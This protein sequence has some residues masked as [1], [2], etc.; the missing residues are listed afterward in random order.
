MGDVSAAL[1]NLKSGSASDDGKHGIF[2]FEQ[3]G[4]EVTIAL[5]AED[6]RYLVAFAA[7]AAQQIERT[8]AEDPEAKFVLPVEWWEI[9]MSKGFAHLVFSFRLPGGSELSFGVHPAQLTA[10]RETLA[11][12]SGEPIQQ[13]PG[14]AKN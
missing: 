11:A 12:L 2:T 14:T 5:S 1:V 13:T 4:E 6:V 10:M 9:G 8:K 3:D 7:K